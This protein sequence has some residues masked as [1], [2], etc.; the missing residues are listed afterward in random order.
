MSE[1]NNENLL[2]TVI[3]P[4]KSEQSQEEQGTTKNGV[5]IFVVPH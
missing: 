4:E 3:R 5:P 2:A 1:L